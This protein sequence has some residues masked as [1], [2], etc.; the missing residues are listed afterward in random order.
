MFGKTTVGSNPV[1]GVGVIRQFG[2]LSGLN[3]ESEMICQ[4]ESGSRR[5]W[6]LSSEVERLTCNEKAVGAVPTASIYALEAEVEKQLVCNHQ[7]AGASPVP[8]FL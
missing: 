8:G 1:L 6:E 4:F 5:S 7:E 3:P 2:C